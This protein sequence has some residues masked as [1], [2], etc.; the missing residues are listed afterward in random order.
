M[1]YEYVV[2]ALSSWLTNLHSSSSFPATAS[3]SSAKLKFVIVLPP[4][5]TYLPWSSKAS[6]MI[7]SSRC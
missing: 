1:P 2:D 7:L 3:M 5:L 4:M 6:V